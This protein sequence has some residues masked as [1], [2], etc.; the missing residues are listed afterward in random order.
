MTTHDFCI[1]F[2]DSFG[3]DS[4]SLTRHFH[5]HTKNTG[6]HMFDRCEFYLEP[7]FGTGGMFIKYFEYEVYSI[8][9]GGIDGAKFF[10]DGVQLPGENIVGYDENFSI[11]F[12]HLLYYFFEFPFAKESFVIR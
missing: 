7:G 8:P 2:T 1:G 5:T 10:I 12:F 11:F 3:A 9:T 4:S 6:S